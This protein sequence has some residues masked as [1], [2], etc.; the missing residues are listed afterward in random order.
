MT[1]W[2]A[3]SFSVKV[4]EDSPERCLVS[5]GTHLS[6]GVDTTVDGAHALW[7]EFRSV[8]LD[9]NKN[10]VFLSISICLKFSIAFHFDPTNKQYYQQCLGPL[11]QDICWPMSHGDGGDRPVS[12]PE[13]SLLGFA[14]CFYQ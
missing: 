6:G 4:I 8:N 10:Y 2:P 9:G 3:L 5:T 12:E 7:T 13:F 11:H 1:L 14:A